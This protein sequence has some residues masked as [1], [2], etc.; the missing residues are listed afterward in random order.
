MRKKKNVHLKKYRL[1]EKSMFRQLV[2]SF[3][4]IITCLCKKEK[5]NRLFK[6]YHPREKFLFLQLVAN[7]AGFW[8]NDGAFIRKNF[9]HFKILTA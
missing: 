2:A 1:R 6:K 3:G 8:R 7:F 4:E 5:T 9:S